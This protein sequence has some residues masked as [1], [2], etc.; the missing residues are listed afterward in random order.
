MPEQIDRIP[1]E[2]IDTGVH[3]LEIYANSRF[4]RFIYKLL[5]FLEGREERHA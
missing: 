2:Y 1:Q 3:N 4:Q 5:D